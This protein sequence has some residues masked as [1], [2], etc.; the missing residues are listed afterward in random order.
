MKI[1]LAGEITTDSIVDG[2]GIRSVIWTQG[3]IHNCPGCHNPLTHSF[4]DGILRDVEDVCDEI[5][6][7]DFQDGITLSGGDPLAQ[8]DACLEIAK[9]CQSINL[10]VW[11]YTGYKMEDLL[12]RCSKESKLKELLLNV[13]VLVDSPFIL[14]LKSYNVPFRGSSNQRII[15]SKKSV[16]ENR[17]CLV[18]KY[19]N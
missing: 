14:E 5:K 9:F 4:T 10:N 19:K 15:D 6:N 13:D 8:I 18:E 7:I 3:C 12:K 17:V 11:C 1:R 2:E 16:K